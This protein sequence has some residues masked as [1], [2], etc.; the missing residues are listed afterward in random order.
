MACSRLGGIPNRSPHRREGAVSSWRSPQLAL[1]DRSK[2]RFFAGGG[3]WF[4]VGIGPIKNSA[5]APLQKVFRYLLPRR[6]C[7]HERRPQRDLLAAIR[8]VP[9]SG[10]SGE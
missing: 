4:E 3:G 7:E 1:E 9:P 2:R 6:P 10:R 8:C 5:A